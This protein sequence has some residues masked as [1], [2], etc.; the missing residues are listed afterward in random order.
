MPSATKYNSSLWAGRNTDSRDALPGSFEDAEECRGLGNYKL[1][2]TLQE[3]HGK[4]IGII[5]IGPA[6]ERK[7]KASS[8]AL[9]DKDGLPTRHAARGGLGAVMCA[10]GLKAVVANDE[11][12]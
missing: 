10:K 8:I 3:K 7:Y 5:S 9:T 2:E 11:G 4:K 12:A 1:A 6:G